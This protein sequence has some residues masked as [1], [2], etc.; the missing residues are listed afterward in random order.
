[1]SLQPN[2]KIWKFIQQKNTK[3]NFDWSL[4]IILVILVIFGLTVLSSALSTQKISDYQSDWFSQLMF[5]VW[6]GGGLCVFI[7]R[8]DYHNWF[9]WNKWLLTITIVLLSYLASFV[10]FSWIARKNLASVLESVKSLPIRPSLKNGALRWINVTFLPSFQP[11]ELAK[12]TFLIF[13]A[14]QFSE[15]KTSAIRLFDLKKVLWLFAFISFIILIQPDLG[16]VIIL[17]T[18]L[19]TS[20]VIG[21]VPPKIILTISGISL[22]IALVAISLYSYRAER[23]STFWD[24]FKNSESACTTEKANSK[25]FQVC[26]AR[27]AIISGGIFGKG[28][29]QGSY[30]QDKDSPIPEISTDAIFA[31]I[32][33][34]FGLIGGVILISLYLFLFIRGMKVSQNAP[35]LGGQIL[36][37]GIV[38]WILFQAFTNIA[39]ITGLIP[40]K[41]I[42]LPFISKGNS[43][44]LFNM[45]AYGILINISSQRV[46]RQNPKKFLIKKYNASNK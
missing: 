28:Y 2:T 24:F 5:G 43:A 23:V 34:E 18:I 26:Q 7:S 19:I 12:I 38:V 44:Y 20:F 40:L 6:I 4:I 10:V 3:Y 42:T 17:F 30:K 22:I 21:K 15:F 45:I 14:K 16:S 37:A 9:K 46:N 33:E 27:Q 32:G 35:D 39:G 25:N 29:N 41:G 11:A 36:A 13:I 8:I 1:M 31:V